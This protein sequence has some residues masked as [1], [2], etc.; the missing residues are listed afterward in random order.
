MKENDQKFLERAIELS[1]QGYGE[2]KWGSHLV[3]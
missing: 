1:R 2:R 3:A